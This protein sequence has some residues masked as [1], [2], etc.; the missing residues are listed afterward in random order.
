MPRCSPVVGFGNWSVLPVDHYITVIN[1]REIFPIRC[2]FF[3]PFEL[4]SFAYKHDYRTMSSWNFLVNAIFC[5]LSGGFQGNY[6][7]VNLATVWYYINLS[8]EK[9]LNEKIKISMSNKQ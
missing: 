5:P 9:I 2:N 8:W 7:K 3:S 6:C 1:R 4:D